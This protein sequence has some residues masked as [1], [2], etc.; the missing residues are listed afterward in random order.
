M[1]SV[2]F[3]RV[4]LVTDMENPVCHIKFVTHPLSNVHAWPQVPNIQ[5][6]IHPGLPEIGPD[7]LNPILVLIIG[8]RIANIYSRRAIRDSKTINLF[9]DLVVQFGH[10][11]SSNPLEGPIFKYKNSQKCSLRSHRGIPNGKGPGCLC[12]FKLACASSEKWARDLAKPRIIC[13]VRTKLPTDPL[14]CL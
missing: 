10:Q 8:F 12:R 2:C 5:A 4:Q 9:W 7:G 1:A 13:R 11:D 6:S 3:L 14:Y